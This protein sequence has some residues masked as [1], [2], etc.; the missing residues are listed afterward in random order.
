MRAQLKS[1]QPNCDIRPFNL[2]GHTILASA[3]TEV[4]YHVESRMV[5]VTEHGNTWV[6]PLSAVASMVPLTEVDASVLL[7]EPATAKKGAKNAS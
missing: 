5:T 4:T 1:I 2:R 6:I 7:E 3:Q